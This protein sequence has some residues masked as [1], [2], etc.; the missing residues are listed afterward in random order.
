MPRRSN[1]PYRVLFLLGPLILFGTY[2]PAILPCHAAQDQPEVAA[3]ATPEI[4]Q[5]APNQAA[6]GSDTTVVIRGRNFSSGAYVSFSD[7]TVHVISTRRTSPTQLETKFSVSQKAKPCTGTLYVSN[8]ASMVAQTPFTIVAAPAP[9]ALPVPPANNVR[10]PQP[11][12]DK[13]VSDVNSPEVAK[14]DPPSAGRGGGATVKVTGKN[15]ASGVKVAFSNPGIQVLETQSN[16]A[17]ELTVLIQIAADAA[18]GP[19]SLFVVNPDD[20]EAE[21]QFEVTAAT[22][23]K[24]PTVTGG[25]GGKT[26][27][28]TPAGGT[29][30]NNAAPDQTFSVYSLSSAIS[31]LQSSGKAKGTLLI[32]GKNLKYEEGGTEVFSIPLSDIKEVEENVVFGVKSGTFHVIVNTGR[33]YNFIASSLKPADTQS[34][35]T[36]LQAALK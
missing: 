20:S 36:S 10:P 22:P 12:A 19:G 27:K 7:P 33:A 23:G 31:I 30:G 8:P 28:T 4:Q 5:V 16:K 34:I 14:V 25:T 29:S 17:T 21:A 18:T 35:V 1:C 3:D 13:A 26:K 6:L 9:T 32:S 24:V 11:N 2:G 15:F